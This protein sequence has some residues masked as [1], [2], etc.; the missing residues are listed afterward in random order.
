LCGFN[1]LDVAFE[2]RYE[3]YEALTVAHV[4]LFGINLVVGTVDAQYEIHATHQLEMALDDGKPGARQ[5]NYKSLFQRSWQ[6]LGSIP[7]IYVSCK[8]L[9]AQR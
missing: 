4:L 7:A 3:V 9:I 2:F 5:T 1:R 6:V 8:V